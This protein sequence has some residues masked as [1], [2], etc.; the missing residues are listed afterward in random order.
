MRAQNY[1]DVLITFFH[2]FGKAVLLSHAARNDDKKVFVF[3]FEFLH[4]A[5]VAKCSAFSG[6]AD[7]AGIENHDVGVFRLVHRAHTHAA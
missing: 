2:V 1:V 6:V 7:T 5:D 3:L 4:F